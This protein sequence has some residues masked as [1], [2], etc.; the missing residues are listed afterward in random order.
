VVEH[1][2]QTGQPETFDGLYRGQLPR[3]AKYKIVY[4][5]EI[6]RK[7]RP[8]GD[9]VPCPMCTPHSPKFLSGV[10]AWFYELQVTS[11][12][13]HCCA[14]HADEAERGYR[15]AQTLER[16][17]NYLLDALPLLKA[18]RAV[19]ESM[20]GPA[21]DAQILYQQFRG[22]LPRLHKHL[23]HIKDHSNAQLV[24]TEA[25]ED[26]KNNAL[27]PGYGPAGYR[28]RDEIKSRDHGFGALLGT[29]AVINNYRPVVELNDAI[30]DAEGFQFD[31][32][33]EAALDFIVTLNAATRAAAMAIMQSLDN[34]WLKFSARIKDFAAFWSAENMR[35]LNAYGT[36][37]FSPISFEARRS[38][39]G[40]R[41]FAII[42]HEGVEL[43]AL[44]RPCFDD[45]ERPWERFAY[46]K[47]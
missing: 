46:K 27:R 34:R 41:S 14:I 30:R 29:T 36:S 8:E 3:D 38:V 37:P 24:A 43:R 47:R 7:K 42:S 25:L 17:E 12:I 10:L 32:D 21:S 18:K 11:V 22:K 23:R 9:M 31:G 16:Q 39:I 6:D 20:K 13:G 40:G 2:K 33:E 45:L 19:L 35:R 1:V 44:I 5:I 28:G 4:K 15:A 26:D